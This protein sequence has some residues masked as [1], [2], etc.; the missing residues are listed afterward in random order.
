MMR[1]MLIAKTTRQITRKNKSLILNNWMRSSRP[2][3]LFLKMY[4]P[5]TLSLYFPLL[6]VFLLSSLCA[7]SFFFSI[8]QCLPSCPPHHLFPSV[9]LSVSLS[10]PL[11]L[12]LFL[13][14]PSFSLFLF[15]CL[16]ILL[17]L[18]L[19]LSRSLFFLSLP[20]FLSTNSSVFQF[21]SLSLSSSYFLFL[22]LSLSLFLFF[23]NFLFLF[24]C[25]K[26]PAFLDLF[27][28]KVNSFSSS[29]TI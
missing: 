7:V 26:L 14:H 29:T 23:S 24:L 11:S 16:P 10:G 20:L 27:G 8:L 1:E 9:P 19:S 2:F 6:S 25:F 3:T 22:S 4:L 17:S 13:A 21:F 5:I 15:F 12:S 28:W 18:S